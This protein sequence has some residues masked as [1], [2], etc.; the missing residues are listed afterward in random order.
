MSIN[1]G[2]IYD[3]LLKQNID[4]SF[5]DVPTPAYLQEKILDCSEATR[6]IEKR[7][8]EVTRELSTKEKDLKVEQSRLEIK[9]RGLIINDPAIKKYPT[10]KEREAAADETL[11]PDQKRVLELQNLQ[12]SIRLVHQNLRT[13]N[14]DIR[15]MMRIMEQQIYRL[16]IGSKTDK[17][18]RHLAASLGEIEQLEQELTPDDVES[19]TQGI[20]PDKPGSPSE[21][22]TQ[23]KTDTVSKEAGSESG[24]DPDTIASFLMDDSADGGQTTAP[25]E[26]SNSEAEERP[27][28]SAVGSE[29]AK[30]QN[31]APSPTEAIGNDGGG[32]KLVTG[33]DIDL[34]DIMSEPQDKPAA[35]TMKP[36]SKPPVT[37]E[38]QKPAKAAAA[39]PE[40]PSPPKKE[41]GETA[42]LDIDDILNSLG[43]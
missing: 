3:Q 11:E 9:R 14:S 8:I 20:D 31:G 29:D 27:A 22:T 10:G 4:L 21:E 33:L 19:S 26:E 1:T 24:E 35:A 39:P 2:E 15:V 18:V 23:S 40:N 32:S 37:K 41:T 36:E 38:E 7:M 25:A 42:E 43:N 28:Q 30:T 16:N 12:S 17:D 13:T 34:G 6:N 5:D